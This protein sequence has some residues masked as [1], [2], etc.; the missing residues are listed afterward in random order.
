MCKIVEEG[1]NNFIDVLVMQW[2]KTLQVALRED[3]H[4]I[5]VINVLDIE[6]IGE[7]ASCIG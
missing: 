2:L 3:L 4:V 7:Q 1:Y 5:I 6:Y